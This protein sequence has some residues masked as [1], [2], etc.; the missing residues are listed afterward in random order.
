MTSANTNTEIWIDTYFTL[1]PEFYHPE[2]YDFHLDKMLHQYYG[3]KN[4]YQEG[5]G[6]YVQCLVCQHFMDIVKREYRNV[7][8]KSTKFTITVRFPENAQLIIEVEEKR[9]KSNLIQLHFQVF[10]SMSQLYDILLNNHSMKMGDFL[11]SWM[12]SLLIHFNE[13]SQKTQNKIEN[14]ETYKQLFEIHL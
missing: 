14:K 1:D 3:I 7:G 13:Q 4:P 6:A 12:N 10:I 2:I 11:K 5:H 8:L 9:T